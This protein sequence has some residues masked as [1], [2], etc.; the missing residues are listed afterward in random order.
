ML[1]RSFLLAAV[2]APGLGSLAGCRH[3]GPSPTAT[4]ASASAPAP[5]TVAPAPK[6][7]DGPL[8]AITAGTRFGER[9]TIAKVP[10]KP[11]KNLAVRTVIAGNGP[12]AA[13]N[14]FLQVNFLG[15]TWDTAKVFDNT[16]DRKAPALIHLA[17]TS[18]M[19]G[20][21]YALTGK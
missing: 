8:P 15:Q 19:D 4:R 16:Y 21:L 14:D 18:V 6:I 13:A 5:I 20:W 12:I 10:G 9:P 7:V 11:S 2:S 1:R 3:T 17:K